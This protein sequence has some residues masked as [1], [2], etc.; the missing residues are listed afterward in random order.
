MKKAILLFFIPFVG[1]AQSD[2][3]ISLP[4]PQPIFHKEHN[5]V[6]LFPDKEAQFPGGRDSLKQYL[7]QLIIPLFVLEKRLQGRVFLYFIVEKDGSIS[8]VQIKKEMEDC[9]ECNKM[10][11]ELIKE[12][13]K[14]TPAYSK[15]YFNE[16]TIKTE[17]LKDSIPV[18]SNFTLPIAFKSSNYPIL[19]QGYDSL[20]H[21]LNTNLIY[22][23][24]AFK[25]KIEGK[26]YVKLLFGETG[27]IKDVVLLKGI[28]NCS[29][30]N[31]E[32][33]RL[34]MSIPKEIMI[35]NNDSLSIQ[36]FI[37]YTYIEF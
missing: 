12:M 29:E 30:C 25:E 36:P 16:Y 4:D 24:Q 9:H 23:K 2:P 17:K 32:A 22:P 18:R 14:W 33:V 26:V 15:H 35:A 3:I 5:G 19:P 13:P 27:E 37:F 20:T 7:N 21:F 8:T 31:E 11:T 6:Q 10:A 1:I 34:T 28:E